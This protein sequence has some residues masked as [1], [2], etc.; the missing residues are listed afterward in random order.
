MP[1]LLPLLVG[2]LL[3][4]IGVYGILARRNAVLVLVGVELMLNAVNLN[5]LAFDAWHRDPLH[6][7]QILT[8]FVIT[9]AAAEI[10]L[11]LAIVLLVFRTRASVDV[12]TA[13]DLA[14]RDAT[15]EAYAAEIAAA[16]AAEPADLLEDG[17]SLSRPTSNNSTEAPEEVRL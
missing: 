17:R 6:S 14:D 7:G 5:L 1:L 8:L 10:G 15:D 9:I 13:R 11:G 16:D 12:E 2:V 3:F 4:A